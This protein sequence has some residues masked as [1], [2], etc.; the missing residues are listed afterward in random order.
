MSSLFLLALLCATATVVAGNPVVGHG[1]ADETIVRLCNKNEMWYDCGPCD[2]TCENLTPA[3]PMMCRAGG[4]PGC[5]CIAD[6]VRDPDHRGCMPKEHCPKVEPAEIRPPMPVELHPPQPA[7]LHQPKPVPIDAHSQPECPDKEQWFACAGC[8]DASCAN[9]DPICPL[10]CL[11]GCRCIEGHVRDPEHKHCIPKE[12]CPIIE[13]GE[14]NPVPAALHPP[15]PVEL[16]NPRPVELGHPKPAELT[17]PKPAEFHPPQPAELHP[18]HFR[19]PK[20]IP[21][22]VNPPMCPENEQWFECGACD[23]SCSETDPRCSRHCQEEGSCGCI[24]DHVRES[25][26]S[27]C[28]HRT[29][30]SRIEPE[31]VHPPLADIHAPLADIHAPLA[32]IHAPL[33]DIRPPVEIV[34][35]PIREIHPPLA[36]I[37]GPLADIHAPL[38]DVHAPL[39]DIHSPLADLHP[40][41]CPDK[42]MWYACGACDGTCSRTRPTC[43]KICRPQGGCGCLPDHVREP[44]AHNC[45]HVSNCDNVVPPFQID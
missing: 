2:A 31:L 36:D 15:K 35:P 25:K 22:A 40:K 8:A 23:G 20:P 39:A 4:R 3:C 34:R 11:S 21:I 6:H 18:P 30:C 33:A 19:P 45:I 10:A 16:G 28:I 26:G 27:R 32:D 14:F 37:H 12:R 7:E 13:P 29:Q 38:A 42:E 44:K 1:T 5:G 17:D 24:K 41:M 9:L 43:S